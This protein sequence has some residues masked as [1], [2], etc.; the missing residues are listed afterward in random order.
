M[1]SMEFSGIPGHYQFDF[2]MSQCTGSYVNWGD[3]DYDYESNIF[4][5]EREFSRWDRS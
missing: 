5:L 4:Q 3:Y 1:V 2:D